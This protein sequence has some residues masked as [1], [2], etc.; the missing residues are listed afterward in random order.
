MAIF[1]RNIWSLF[2][3][4]SLGGVFLLSVILVSRWQSLISE[5]ESYHLSRAELVAQ[6]VDSLLRTQ[7]LVLDVVG[8]ELLSR[9]NMFSDSRQIP[10]L[11]NILSVNPTIVGFGLARP[12]G[13]LVRVSSNIDVSKLPNLRTHPATRDS[14]AEALRSDAMVLGRTYFV[15]AMD[16]WVIPIRKALR[17]QEGKVI[18]VMTAGLRLG[19]GSTIF[20]QTLHDGADDS[21]ML[22]RRSDRYVQFLSR[23]GVGP[24]QYSRIQYSPE[25]AASFRRQLEQGL[26]LNFDQ[27]L[28]SKQAMAVRMR[29][30]GKEYLTAALF[31]DRYQLWVISDTTMAPIYRDF[32][33]TVAAYL[34]IFLLVAL[35][36]FLM[37]RVID[38]AERKRRQELVYVS[39][40]DEL[41]GLLNRAGLIDRLDTLIP[42]EKPFS[43][44]VV[45]IDNFKGI[46]D[47]FGQESGDEALVAFSFRLRRLIASDDDLA[48]LG[49]DE[50]VILTPS[51]D[52]DRVEQKSISLVDSMAETFD[53]GRLRLQ[54]T[55]SVGVASFPSHGDS[56]S[57]LIRSAHLALYEAKQSRNSVCI[58][59]NDMELSYLRQLKVEQRLRYGLAS[60][61]LSM[62]YQ[63]QVDRNADIVGMEA[64][65]R[66]QDEM[67]GVVSPAEFVDVAEKS[68][69]MVPLGRFVLET[70]IREFGELRPDLERPL[71]LAINISII[72][73]QQPDFVDHLMATLE[74]HGVPASELVLEITETLFMSRFDQVLETLHRV[75]ALGIRVSM[76]DFGTGYS[77]L[78]LLRRLPIDELKIDKSFVDGILDDEKAANMIRSIIAIAQ[79]HNMELVAEGVEEE[80]QAAALV[81]M[82]CRRFQGYYFGKPGALDRIRERLAQKVG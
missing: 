64:L 7:E 74:R 2:V 44:I 69:L 55:A 42:R 60:N 50:F 14:F 65:V 68:G 48:R 36:V 29:R 13:T 75:R 33:G 35:V 17:T 32:V 39:R 47:Q 77:S 21:V 8:R 10:L 57:K 18:A 56:L 76:D 27:V 19:T 70:S 15:D 73:F 11:D 24:A 52:L 22:Y 54:V 1:R 78:S 16:A 3:L 28:A 30:D 59:R 46:N 58:Y 49:G 40:H 31:N 67:L 66:W 4:I 81:R 53:M 20:D 51:T 43:L 45:N 61:A 79:S 5:Y 26:G 72:Q 25:Q 80:A 41:T 12:D 71:D 34:G 62:V 82:G 63:P 9:E 37:V 23:E 38:R 6:S